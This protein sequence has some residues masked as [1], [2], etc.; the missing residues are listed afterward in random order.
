MITLSS[1]PSIVSSSAFG[2]LLPLTSL[3]FIPDE[4]PL[5]DKVRP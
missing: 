4:R 5:N 2:R 3:K 1:F